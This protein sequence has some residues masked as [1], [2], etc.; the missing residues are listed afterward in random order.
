MEGG[1]EIYIRQILVA[2]PEEAM[3][4]LNKISTGE[5]F[6]AL[7]AE[8]SLARSGGHGGYAGHFQASELDPKLAGVLAGRNPFDDP[9][10][11]ETPAGYLVLQRIAPF[12]PAYWDELL[13]ASKPKAPIR[14]TGDKPSPTPLRKPQA[15]ETGYLV[16]AGSYAN[17]E[18]AQELLEDLRSHG[19]KSYIYEKESASTGIRYHVVAGKYPSR[20][21]AQAA[22]RRLGNF[23]FDFFVIE[24]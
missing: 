17:R 24:E 6:E 10:T 12:D 23:G 16:H 3:E 15:K 5:L 13:S 20:E 14:N 1:K 19:F 18:Y 2:S 11:V 7:A 4:L 22:G 21:E 8:K 9:V